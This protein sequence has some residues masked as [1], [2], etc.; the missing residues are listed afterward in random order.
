MVSNNWNSEIGLLRECER[1]EPS[2][3]WQTLAVSFGGFAIAAALAALTIAGEAA[4]RPAE[5]WVAAAGFS[6]AAVLCLAAHRDVNRG[7]KSKW[8]E[9]EE[10]PP[11]RGAREDGH[12]A[13]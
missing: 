5:L 2:V 1:P 4:V 12:R 13:G 10:L 7:R 8:I 11:S 3:I 9:V 6:L